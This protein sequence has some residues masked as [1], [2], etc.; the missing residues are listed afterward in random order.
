MLRRTASA[1]FAAGMFVFPGGRVDGV[2]A[3]M[4]SHCTGLDDATASRLL[5]LESGGLAYWVAAVRECFEEAGVLLARHRDGRPVSPGNDDRHA[6][7]DGSLQLSELC[8]RDDLVVDVAATHY[9]AHWITPVGERRRFDTR[10][11][12][13]EAPPDQEPA[14]DDKET[15]DS[16]WIRPEEA[17]R[18]R[19]ARRLMILPPTI[20]CLRFLEPHR[21][22]ADALAAAAAIVDPPPILPTLRYDDDGTVTGVEAPDG[23]VYDMR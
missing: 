22:A 2:D 15:V 4:A 9:V 6:V 23:T 5:N 11:F 14:H 21:S 8:R 18:E 17:L 7:H 20:A 13:A 1:A 16:L 19:E 12:V 10:F 3:E